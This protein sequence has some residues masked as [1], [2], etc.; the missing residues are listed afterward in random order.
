MAYCDFLTFIPHSFNDRY[1]HV[2]VDDPMPLNAT[3]WSS[4]NG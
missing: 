3:R 1:Y 2:S 4:T